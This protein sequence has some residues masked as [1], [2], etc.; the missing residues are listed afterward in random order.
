LPPYEITTS[1]RSMGLQ[2]ISQPVRRGARYV[3]RAIDRRGAEVTV[4]ADA[5]SGRILF[6]RPVGYGEGP[7]YADR[8]YPRLVPQET[9]P[10]RGSYERPP[11]YEQ[12]GDYQ[13]QGNYERPPDR[14][15]ARIPGEPSV[16]YA[17]RDSANSQ[18][19]TPLPP[20]RAPS[21][22]KPPAPKVA[23]KPPA[24][25]APAAAPA[26]AP[27]TEQPSE[28]TTGATSSPATSS[29]PAADKPPASKVAEK[30]P[31]PAAAPGEASKTEQP[32]DAPTGPTSSPP[33]K[34]NPALTAPPV[35]AFD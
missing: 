18:N 6:V 24:H 30:P 32:S 29:P 23:A 28:V 26:E 17:P 13:Q 10:P 11:S 8:Y 4:A 7:A 33:A 12:P 31:A 27:K 35:Q 9:V 22:A 25:A 34:K 5:L 2:P 21:A 3:L 15:P 20:A 1:V 16:I 14:P 19:T